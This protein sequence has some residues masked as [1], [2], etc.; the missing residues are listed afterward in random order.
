MVHSRNAQDETLKVLSQ[1][2]N[3]KLRGVIHC[4]SYDL[5]IAKEFINLGF[6]LGIGGH[7]HISKK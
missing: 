6:V 3:N 2:K 1:F 7:N 5:S 4:F